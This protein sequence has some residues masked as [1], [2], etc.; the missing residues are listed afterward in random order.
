MKSSLFILLL[1]VAT[2]AHAA[3]EPI[4]K[5]YEDPNL[6]QRLEV[7]HVYRTNGTESLADIALRVYGHRT[8]WSKLR[9]RN[10]PV[11][12]FGSSESLPRGTRIHYLAPQVEQT[13][14]V[15]KGDNLYRIALWHFGSAQ[16]W[17]K[18][19]Q[20]NAKLISNPDLIH[21]GVTLIVGEGGTFQLAENSEP[22]SE[23][24]ARK[25]HAKAPIPSSVV[26][27]AVPPVAQKKIASA[28]PPLMST[29]PIPQVVARPPAPSVGQILPPAPP[30]RTPVPTRNLAST[31]T[32]SK[33]PFGTSALIGLIVLFWAAVVVAGYVLW[34]RWNQPTVTTQ[35]LF[36]LDPSMG[37]ENQSENEEFIEDQPS[38]Q[39]LKRLSGRK[40]T[41]LWPVKKDEGKRRSG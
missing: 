38:Y 10:A 34:S 23:P 33:G 15:Q 27:K 24:V 13:Y 14:V 26:A 3:Q 7:Q 19:Y 2:T 31:K 29:P 12:A 4:P 1:L 30:V 40:S 41:K 21:P 5:P 32:L 37:V 36:D 17:R 20:N 39:N 25:V 18:V 11:K 8:W 22:T 9:A 16:P 35:T 6:E 28:A